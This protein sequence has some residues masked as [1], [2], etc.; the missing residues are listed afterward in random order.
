MLVALLSAVL[1]SVEPGQ[2]IDRDQTPT[3]AVEERF[4]RE[5][6]IRAGFAPVVWPS[7]KA[8]RRLVLADPYMMLPVPA[9]EIRQSAEGAVDLVVQYS[10]WASDPAPLDPQVWDRL[11]ADERVFAPAPRDVGRSEQSGSVCHAWSGLLQSS[12]G[13]TTAWHG[14]SG[15]PTPAYDASLEMLRVAMSTRPDCAFD[16]ASPFFAFNACF[17][18]ST[19]LDDPQ[20]AAVFR[21]LRE[22]H[23][24]APGGA[25]LL[26]ARQALRAMSDTPDEAS[27]S[28]A[29]EA[30]F[31]FKAINDY[32][33]ERLQLLIQLEFGATDASAP[34]R[35]RMRR[36]IEAWSSSLVGQERNYMAL[37]EE[38]VRKSS[39]APTEG[40]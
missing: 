10:G 2:A 11:M 37:L 13:R 16:E 9:L 31:A 17:K 28:R 5:R 39:G 40:A 18:A 12:E 35:I 27:W 3:S 7:P 8:F 33:R 32:R 34:D 15:Q 20:R 30:A 38:L 23:D 21:R 25:R 6:F 29:R 1:V 19:D 24:A 36:T 26:E 22:E 4:R 14:C